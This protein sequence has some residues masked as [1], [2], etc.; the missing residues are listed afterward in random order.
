MALGCPIPSAPL[1][2]GS[3]AG[4]GVFGGLVPI[5]GPGAALPETHH[6][7]AAPAGSFARRNPAAVPGAGP[8]RLRLPWSRPA[9]L[10]SPCPALRARSVPTPLS[11]WGSTAPALLKTH[12][13]SCETGIL[14]CIVIQH[15]SISST[16]TCA[17]LPSICTA[18]DSPAGLLSPSG[19][20]GG[21][22]LIFPAP[23]DDK[24][25]QGHP[26][27]CAAL[28]RCAGL[29]SKRASSRWRR[30]GAEFVLWVTRAVCPRRG[31]VTAGRAGAVKGRQGVPMPGDPRLQGG[32]HG[33]IS[34]S[35]GR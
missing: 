16:I 5:P 34:G 2:A 23:P 24:R 7:H 19:L 20:S 13:G 29:L 25:I 22:G 21:N 1:R 28:P 10:P 8:G 12:K 9:M 31:R 4:H 18:G 6:V 11:H 14:V 32:H 27:L 17:N 3:T 26:A 30:K 15:R 33:V 35:V